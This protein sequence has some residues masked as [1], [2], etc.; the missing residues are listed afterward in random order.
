MNSKTHEGI[1]PTGKC[2]I[3]KKPVYQQTPQT[4]GLPTCDD[5]KLLYE[6]YDAIKITRAYLDSGKDS[7]IIVVFTKRIDKENQHCLL[8]III[9]SG[10]MQAPENSSF[11]SAD[12]AMNVGKAKVIELLGE[13]VVFEE[14][15]IDPNDPTEQ[16]KLVQVSAKPEDIL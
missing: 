15:Q 4:K 9:V 2:F 12:E 13:W 6:Q 1:T 16:L 7:A 3:C 5:C 14:V 11:K 10:G 8:Q